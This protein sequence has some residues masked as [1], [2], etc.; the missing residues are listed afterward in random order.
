[1]NKANA[2]KVAVLIAGLL[3]GQAIDRLF[4]ISNAVARMLAPRAAA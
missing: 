1:M 2:E 3:A 4:G